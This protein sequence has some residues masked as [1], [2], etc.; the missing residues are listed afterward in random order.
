M[1]KV[2]T[3]PLFDSM[4]DAQRAP[5]QPQEAA[6]QTPQ[7]TDVA[8]AYDSTWATGQIPEQGPVGTERVMLAQDKLYVVLAVVLVIWLGIAYYI[9]RTD[10]KI[11]ALEKAASERTAGEGIPK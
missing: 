11:V 1:N 9:F 3:V 4:Q 10:R 6:Q 8:T 2:M 7:E 5:D